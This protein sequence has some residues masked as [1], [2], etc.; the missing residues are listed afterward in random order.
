MVRLKHLDCPKEK[1]LAFDHPL[2]FRLRPKN[3]ES[4]PE[5]LFTLSMAFLNRANRPFCKDCRR[6]FRSEHSGTLWKPNSTQPSSQKHV[7]SQDDLTCSHKQDNRELFEFQDPAILQSHG[8]TIPSAS[9]CPRDFQLLPQ[10]GELRPAN[11]PPQV[12]LASSHAPGSNLGNRNL[13]QRHLLGP[14]RT[15]EAICRLNKAFLT[16]GTGEMDLCASANSQNKPTGQVD[17][18]F[19]GSALKEWNPHKGTSWQVGCWS[20]IEYTGISLHP[21]AWASSLQEL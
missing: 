11:A 4:S 13:S 5:P 7:K 19:R 18:A 6:I 20:G 12:F 10:H 8:V 3:R 21:R 14:V 1:D 15:P 16:R 17:F 2:R 9:S